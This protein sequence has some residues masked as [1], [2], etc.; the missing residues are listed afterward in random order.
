MTY[1]RL[2]IA[3]GLSVRARRSFPTAARGAADARAR[4]LNT[5]PLAPSHSTDQSATL[6]PP[7]HPWGSIWSAAGAPLTQ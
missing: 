7:A 3:V 5:R 6:P 2:E 4:D 1:V